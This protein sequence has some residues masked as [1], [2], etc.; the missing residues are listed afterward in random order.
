MI[1]ISKKSMS[2]QVDVV[3]LPRNFSRAMLLQLA[4]DA[5]GLIVD[6]SISLAR[7]SEYKFVFAKHKKFRSSIFFISKVFS[8]GLI[9]DA[10]AKSAAADSW[11]LFHYFFYDWPASLVGAKQNFFI[12]NTCDLIC[13][14]ES[15]I[16]VVN[17]RLTNI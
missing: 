6:Y 7:N 8:D 10:A 16:S 17:E 5:N 9:S 14:V 11:I 1:F 2:L 4:I 13:R 3:D 12:T 15:A